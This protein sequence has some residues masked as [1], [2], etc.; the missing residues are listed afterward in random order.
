MKKPTKRTA[1]VRYLTVRKN[2]SSR[3]RTST[4]KISVFNVIPGARTK[5]SRAVDGVNGAAAVIRGAP[6]RRPG[7]RAG[8]AAEE[9]EQTTF[10]RSSQGHERFY[11]GRNVRLVANVKRVRPAPPRRRALTRAAPRRVVI[12]GGVPGAAPV[13]RVLP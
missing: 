2:V 7:R 9:E 5:K 13:S 12:P 10:V 3:K 1:V 11:Q 4:G 8:E 6:L